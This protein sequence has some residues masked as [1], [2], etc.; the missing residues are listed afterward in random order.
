VIFSDESWLCAEA[1][2]LR[3]VRYL[4]GEIPS[5]EYSL[6]NTKFKAEKK[7][8]AWAAISYTGSLCLYFI[9]R[10]DNIDVYEQIL[11]EYLP[12]IKELW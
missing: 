7:S 3:Y 5:K 4:A 2:H 12:E 6:K 8:L 11:D 1:F 10:K 9:E